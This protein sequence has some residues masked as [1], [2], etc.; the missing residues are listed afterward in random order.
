MH[1]QFLIGAGIYSIAYFNDW[2]AAMYI[3]NCSEHRAG[4]AALASG[5]I[6]VIGAI[7]MAAFIHEPI[8]L[9]P[10]LA[11]AMWGTYVAVKMDG[12][13]PVRP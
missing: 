6:L 7:T 1:E 4:Q 12:R 3:I 10:E 5:A 8:Y 11:G 2:L 9:L 13:R